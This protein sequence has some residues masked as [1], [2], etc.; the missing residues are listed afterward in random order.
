M[1]YPLVLPGPELGVREL[2]DTVLLRC[3]NNVQVM[4]ETDSFELMRGLLADAQSIGFQVKIGA[5][6]DEDHNNLV[7]TPISRPDLPFAALFSVAR[8]NLIRG[9]G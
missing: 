6:S 8:Q 2:L 3:C 9:S 4:A 5:A 7:S 1:D